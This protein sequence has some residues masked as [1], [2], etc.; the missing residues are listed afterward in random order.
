MAEH[1]L[2]TQNE[3]WVTYIEQGGKNAGRNIGH[4][5]VIV[6][7]NGEVKDKFVDCGTHTRA[8]IVSVLVK[9]LTAQEQLEWVNSANIND[10][11]IRVQEIL[12]Q[13]TTIDQVE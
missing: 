7:Q 4:V 13:R 11:E 1:P 5:H 12:Q 9:T 6:N 8:G 10:A 3:P 2:A